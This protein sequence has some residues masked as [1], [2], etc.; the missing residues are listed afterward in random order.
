MF[1]DE[2]IVGEGKIASIDPSANVH[3]IPLGRD[4]WKVWVDDVYMSNL[5]LYRPTKNFEFLVKPWEVQ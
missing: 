3:H 4:C 1:E 2:E 5:P